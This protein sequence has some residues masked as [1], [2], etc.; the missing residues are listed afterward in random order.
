MLK[1]I[2][3][4]IFVVLSI[5]VLGLFSW[6]ETPAP[7][8]NDNFEGS[9]YRLGIS[10][11]FLDGLDP[12]ATR[13]R[14]KTAVVFLTQAQIN[15]DLDQ[16][17]AELMGRYAYLRYNEPDYESAIQ[18]IRD[19]SS[20]GMSIDDFDIELTKVLALSIDGHG[21][22][23]GGKFPEGFLPFRIDRIGNRYIAF[24]ADR[25]DFVS[26]SYPFI[27]KI[28]DLS[29]D[30]WRA[31][32]SVVVSKGSPS[33][34]THYGL[35]YLEY[36]RFAR[37]IAG[38][39]D[40]DVVEIELESRDGSRRVTAVLEIADEAPIVED[41]PVSES[42]FLAGNI[43]YLRI[44]RWLEDAFEEVATWMPRFAGARGLIIDIRDNRG[45]TRSV[46]PE[47][48]PYFVSASDP[49]H[50][51][52]AAK[53]RLYS[54]FTYDH[55][56]GRNMYRESWSGWTPAERSAISG[57]METFEPEWV[58]RESEFSD[59]HFWL[60][61]KASKPDAYDFQG[62]IIFLMNKL[63]WSASD[64]ILSSVKG[65]PNVTLIGEPSVGGSGARI[66]TTLR[67]SGLDL[68]MSSM[69]SFQNTGQLFETNGVQPDIYLEPR[70]E[71]FLQGGDDRVLRYAIQR[72]VGTRR[73]ACR[74]GR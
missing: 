71:F 24:W 67:N 54:E 11:Q 50:V 15:E 12:V 39:D 47:F 70:P 6:A 51:A 1:K 64:V 42:G 31:A 5:V 13:S 58:V 62:P 30:E 59:W 36:I 56:A 57:F 52:N 38:V 66:I 34:Q 46:L 65:L 28:D 16:F 9:L 7:F 69:V 73:A 26:S 37:S 48:Y 32:L 27:T 43:A 2:M 68:Y 17:Q 55:L 20:D 21:G 29:I 25:R 10:P 19:N 45:G 4:G 53:Y 72:I 49:P 14:S 60:L 35:R 74:V 18:A 63:C 8:L 40:P 22:V 41:W 33:Y 3:A 61:S 23:A 44:T